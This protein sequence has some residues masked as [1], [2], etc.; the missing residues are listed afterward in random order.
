MS[1]GV[2]QFIG[3]PGG[4]IAPLFYVKFLPRWLKDQDA[5]KAMKLANE[6]VYDWLY[7]HTGD[8]ANRWLDRN[9]LWSGTQAQLFNEPR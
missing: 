4:N 8:F 6:D 5:G 3:H 9:E 2:E 1:L 7:G